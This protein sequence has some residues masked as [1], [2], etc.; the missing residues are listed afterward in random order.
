MT[1]QGVTHQTRTSPATH[2]PPPPPAPPLPTIPV[3]PHLRTAHKIAR[4]CFY[5]RAEGRGP[6]GHSQTAQQGAC[7]QVFVVG[8]VRCMEIGMQRGLGCDRHASALQQT[9]AC[10][11]QAPYLQGAGPAMYAAARSSLSCRCHVMW[12]ADTGGSWNVMGAPMRCSVLGAGPSGRRVPAAQTTN[13][14]GTIHHSCP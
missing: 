10:V 7:C 3:V 11:L 4:T 12:R 13:D 1:K 8:I 6:R 9:L 2:S 5:T 14:K